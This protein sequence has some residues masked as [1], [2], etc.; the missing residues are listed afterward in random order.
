[1]KHD[2]YV[3]YFDLILRI[4]M[5][6]GHTCQ[7]LSVTQTFYQALWFVL[8]FSETHRITNYSVTAFVTHLISGA[9]C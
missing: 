6:I 3:V 2:Y 8:A 4:Q 1:M 9:Y 5:Y 7:I